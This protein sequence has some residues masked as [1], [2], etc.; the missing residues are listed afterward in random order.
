[1]L[2]VIIPTYNEAENIPALLARLAAI[3]AG[4]S[5]P[6]EVLIVD[7][8]SPDGTA[9]VAAPLLRRTQLGR[10]IERRGERGLA[11]AVREGWRQA[12]G[13]VL[14]VMDAD[15]SH[16]P[17][18]LPQLL[19]ALRAGADIAVASRYVPGG[20][21][22][23]WPRHRRWL[24]RAGNGMA[25]PLTGVRDSLSG[26]FACHVALARSLPSS[27]G[28]GFTMRLELL[29]RAGGQRVREVPYVFGD[30]RAGRSKLGLHPMGAYVTQ[31]ARLY[32]RRV[33]R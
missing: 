12:H 2:S 20:E 16:P 30:R 9:E 1:M 14:A 17:E 24:S 29:T 5:E 23:G 22:P 11:G 32:A 10:V 31:L 33:W 13:D 27:T 7:D 4:M 26:Y 21:V 15:L 28:G 18:L 6:L 8:G 19:S 3:R 25:Q